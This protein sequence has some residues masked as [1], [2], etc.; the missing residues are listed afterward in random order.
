[1]GDRAHLAAVAGDEV[2][3]M[4]MARLVE[5]GS[6]AAVEAVSGDDQAAGGAG[7]R[8]PGESRRGVGQH[9]AEQGRD[10]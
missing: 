7:G 9:Q 1:M 10:D 3:V 6:G 2:H 4:P 5:H 8:R